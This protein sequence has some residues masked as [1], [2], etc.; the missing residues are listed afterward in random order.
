M[1]PFFP[2]I[3]PGCEEVADAFFNCFDT[4]NEPWGSQEAAVAAMV[5]CKDH[6]AKYEQCTRES[7]IKG[8]KPSS[9][10]EYA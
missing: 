4:N 7:L 3:R 9:L 2:M 5:T 1:P 6:Q 8:P 10:T